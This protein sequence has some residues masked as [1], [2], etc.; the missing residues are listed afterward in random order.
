MLTSK[1]NLAS[2]H[3]WSLN[4]L[5]VYVGPVLSQST[6]SACIF[7]SSTTKPIIVFSKSDLKSFLLNSHCILDWVSTSIVVGC[8]AITTYWTISEEFSFIESKPASRYPRILIVIYLSWCKTWIYH[9]PSR[10]DYKNYRCWQKIFY[11]N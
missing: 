1:P 8:G 3:Y 9:S 11:L 4:L 7:W 6:S 5:K 10:C 2:S